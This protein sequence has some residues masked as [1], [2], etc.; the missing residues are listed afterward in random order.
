MHPFSNMQIPNMRKLHSIP[1]DTCR[2]GGGLKAALAGCGSEA[3]ATIARPVES[4]GDAFRVN[5]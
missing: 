5:S 4:E 1:S 3:G 2:D